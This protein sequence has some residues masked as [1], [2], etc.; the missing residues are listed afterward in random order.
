MEK[1]SEELNEVKEDVA[2][3]LLHPDDVGQGEGPLGVD[4]SVGGG[5]PGEETKL[6]KV[7]HHNSQLREREKIAIMHQLLMITK[8]VSHQITCV[9]STILYS[10]RSSTWPRKR[11]R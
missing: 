4:A 6:G 8:L 2:V 9:L 5:G 7:L 11:L 10:V 1:Q 3:L